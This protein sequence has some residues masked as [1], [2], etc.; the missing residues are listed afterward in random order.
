MK[1]LSKN[2]FHCNL[3]SLIFGNPLKSQNQEDHKV[4]V[5]ASIPILNAMDR[6]QGNF[7]QLDRFKSLC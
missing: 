1:F 6:M 7:R 5:L 2:L 3:S 4:G